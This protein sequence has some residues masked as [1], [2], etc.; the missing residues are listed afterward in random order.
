MSEIWTVDSSLKHK[1][2]CIILLNVGGSLVK[3]KGIRVYC[4]TFR[5]RGPMAALFCLYTCHKFPM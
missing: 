1:H 2:T 3:P 5:Y 4:D